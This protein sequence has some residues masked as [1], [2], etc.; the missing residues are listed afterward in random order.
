MGSNVSTED[1]FLKYQHVRQLTQKFREKSLKKQC[2]P[3]YFHPIL[4]EVEDDNNKKVHIKLQHIE[5]LY[6]W[7]NDSTDAIP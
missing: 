6:T 4:E 1:F 7:C 3:P 2:V 5:W